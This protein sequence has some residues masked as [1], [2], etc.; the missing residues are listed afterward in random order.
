MGIGFREDEQPS[1]IDVIG[2]LDKR[3][4]N[5]GNVQLSSCILF[6]SLSVRR[7][8]RYYEHCKIVFMIGKVEGW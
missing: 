7:F 3:G 1:I 5:S 2:E 4:I 8:Y 6:R